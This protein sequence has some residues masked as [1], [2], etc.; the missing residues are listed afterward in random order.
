MDGELPLLKHKMNMIS[1]CKVKRPFVTVIHTGLMVLLMPCQEFN[2]TI[3]ITLQ[4]IQ[5]LLWYGINILSQEKEM[6][7]CSNLLVIN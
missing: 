5:V 3:L 6:I 4:I 7:C 1:S 2:L